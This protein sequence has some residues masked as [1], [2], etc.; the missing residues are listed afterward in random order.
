MV[1]FFSSKPLTP[2]QDQDTGTQNVFC[3]HDVLLH[4]QMTFSLLLSYCPNAYNKQRYS[5]T[6]P[7]NLCYLQIFNLTIKKV[8]ISLVIHWTENISTPY[9]ILYNKTGNSQMRKKDWPVI[10]QSYQ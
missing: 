5:K 9:M 7:N 3:R 1:F 2:I 4:F 8:F 10:A 6:W